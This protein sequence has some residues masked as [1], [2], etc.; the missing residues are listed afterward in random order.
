MSNEILWETNVGSHMWKMD[1]PDSDVDIFEAYIVDTKDLLRGKAIT[2]SYQKHMPDKNMDV[3]G[4]EIGTIINQ[5]LKGNMNYLW[6]VT[7]PIVISQKDT[8]IDRL[9]DIVKHNVAKNCANSIRGMVVGNYNKYILYGSNNT[10]TG[11]ELQ[12]KCNMMCRSLDFGIRLLEG[13]GFV[14][15]AHNMGTPD[16]VKY[17]LQKIDEALGNSKLPEFPI[18]EP[19]RN[20][21]LDLR[22]SYL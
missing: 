21:L 3:S 15:T 4:H 18:E 16:D 8:A 17:L 20:F 19:Y 13:R 5:L 12:K 1:R 11:P 14:Y 2:A 10:C 6:G 7:S 9:Y 22:M